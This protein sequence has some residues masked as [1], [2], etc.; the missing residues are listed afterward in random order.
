MR[1]NKERTGMGISFKTKYSSKEL[2]DKMNT[3]SEY[4]TG[5][6]VPSDVNWEGVNYSFYVTHRQSLKEYINENGITNNDF[7]LFI[8][9]IISLLEKAEEYNIDP[10]EFVFDYECVFIGESL[11]EAEFIYAPDD[12]TYKDGYVLH[13]KCS[14]MASIVSL[15]IETQ[16]TNSNKQEENISEILRILYEWENKPLSK[17]EP[18]PKEALMPLIAR[19]KMFFD[20]GEYLKEKFQKA[21]DSFL[22]AFVSKGEVVMKLNGVMLLKGVKYVS[23][24]EKDNEINIGRDSDWADLPVGMMFISRKHATIYKEN[25]VWYIKDLNSKNGTFV[26]GTR[27]VSDRPFSLNDGY[28]ISFGLSESKLIF[29]LP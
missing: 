14:D 19:S 27:I 25:G 12:E 4:L 3:V 16:G 18:F 11:A 20:V 6:F 13:N 2:K 22:K 7:F 9:S 23:E 26:N 21:Y 1:I 5:V 24:S 29:C 28:E 8:N 17:K 10:H 15:H